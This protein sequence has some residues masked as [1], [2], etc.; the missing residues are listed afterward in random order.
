[1]SRVAGLISQVKANNADQSS[2]FGCCCAKN[3][4][5]QL[6]AVQ[7][8]GDVAVQSI[9]RRRHWGTVDASP[10][11]VAP[12]I[13]TNLLEVSRL[14]PCKWSCNHLSCPSATCKPLRTIIPLFVRAGTQPLRQRR[15]PHCQCP[16][17]PSPAHGLV[18]RVT[19]HKKNNVPFYCLNY[20]NSPSVKQ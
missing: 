6:G 10:P 20:G 17:G 7:T 9:A 13:R 14:R 5:V 18:L 3:H 15:C 19:A 2:S 1:M 11:S 16:A 8:S 12:C 4:A